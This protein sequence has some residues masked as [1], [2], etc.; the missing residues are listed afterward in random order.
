MNYTHINEV[1]AQTR[2]ASKRCYCFQI[3][4]NAVDVCNHLEQLKSCFVMTDGLWPRKHGIQE[5]GPGPSSGQLRCRP[6][7]YP[8]RS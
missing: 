4:H 5:P 6:C 1:I 3:N 2:G 7:I 8:R